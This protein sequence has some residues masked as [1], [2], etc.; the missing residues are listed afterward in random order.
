MR[1]KSV[2]LKEKFLFEVFVRTN[3]QITNT[4]YNTFIT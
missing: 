1:V 4:P 3:L 2:E